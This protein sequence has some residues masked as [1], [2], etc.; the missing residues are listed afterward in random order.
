MAVFTTAQQQDLLKLGVGMFNASLGGLMVDLAA[1]L[2]PATGTGMTL[3]QLYETLANSPTFTGLNFATSDAST[4][5]QFAAYFANQILGTSVGPANVTAAAAYLERLLDGGQTRGAVMKTAVDFLGSAAALADTSWGPAA[6]QFVNKV[7]VATDYT[8]TKSGTAT[9]LSALQATIASVT[10]AAASV[11]AATSGATSVTT[12]RTFTLTTGADVITGTADNDLV[13]ANNTRAT[14]TLGGADQIDLGAGT[15]T[16]KVYLAAADT[17]T[18]AP[19][20]TGVETFYING[21]AIAALTAPTGITT[22]SID[23][24]VVNTAA[25]YTV[26]GQAVVLARHT[27]TANRTTTIASATDTTQNITVN[28]QSR[29]GANVNTLDLSGT[30]VAT[31]NLTATGADSTL[32]VNNT[33]AALTTL[34]IA[35]DKNLTL[36]ERTAAVAA[37]ITTIDARAATGNVSVDASAALTAG[38]FKYT[39]GSG[40]DTVTF[41]DDE[42][43]T[44]VAGSQLDGGAGTGDKIGLRDTALSAAETAKINATIGF[45]VLGLNAAISLDASTLTSIK[46]FSIDT[47]ALAQSISSMATGSTVTVTAAAPASL[48]VATNSG[49]TDTTIALGT[50]TSTGITVATL[51][52]TGITHVTL[53]SNGTAANAITAL[54]NSDNSAFAITGADD[55]TI[56]LS[57]GTAIGSTVDASAFTGKL[58]VTASNIIASGDVII[59]GSGADA[60]N[61]RSG[62]DILTGGAG[63]DI[64]SFTNVNAGGTEFGQGD[65]ITDFVVG[66]D[67]LQ[68]AGVPDVVSAQQDLVQAVVT[69]LPAGSSAVAIADAMATASDTAWGVSFAVFGGNTYVLM[70]QTT[71]AT[72][73]AANDVFIKLAGIADLTTFAADVIA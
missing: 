42:F 34:N 71:G 2:A 17:D 56:A 23:A 60:I 62:A 14:K 39:G 11:I 26:A 19:A 15:D 10:S 6:Q 64:Y 16:V 53:S 8:I 37:A 28:G 69:A 5:A 51:V 68:F 54:T 40:T 67:R 9:T 66:T 12:G 55:L 18:G 49:V 41:I 58:T 33:G 24:P 43:G 47:T 35:G 50:S 44:L 36:A 25:T 20:F 32:S 27:V 73:N 72:G 30:K 4:N 22:L 57:A 38:A 29:T 70:E 7:T 1:A 21:G 3:A 65:V 13:I 59:G 48:T 31:L 45:E 52:T 46:K 61:G 63:A